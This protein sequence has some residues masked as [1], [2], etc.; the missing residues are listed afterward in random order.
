MKVHIVFNITDAASGG[1][2]QFLKCL[3]KFFCSAGIYEEYPDKA[4]VI[5]FNSHQNI[6]EAAAIKLKCPD[7]AFI[8]RIDGPMTLYN[9]PADKRDKVVYAANEYLADATVFQSNWSRENNYRLSLEKK[10]LEL[11]ITNAPDPDIFNRTGKTDFSRNRKIRLISVSWSSNWKKGFDVYGWLDK[12]LDFEKYEM[13][14]VG[15]SPVKFDNIVC[16]KPL[17][18]TELAEKLKNSDIFIIA[19]QNDPCSNSLIEAMH[20]GLPALAL[21]SGGHPEII[22]RGGELFNEPSEIPRLIKKITDNY[23]DYVSSI[24]LPAIEDVG[25][26]Y[27]DFTQ[28]VCARIK[29]VPRKKFARIDYLCLTARIFLWKTINKINNAFKVSDNK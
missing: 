17:Q 10:E 23:S 3:R 21:N 12:N 16:L 11:V 5:I 13:L 28:K 26:E 2:N 9:R 14:F 7:K 1:G 20:C 15:N 18:S 8:H 6:H 29:Q 24:K 25:G 19:S 22:R 27:Y 4:D